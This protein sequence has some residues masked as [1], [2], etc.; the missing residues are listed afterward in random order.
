MRIQLCA[1]RLFPGQ[2]LEAVGQA[3]G[4]QE[5]VPCSHVETNVKRQA[6]EADV[7]V[8]CDIILANEV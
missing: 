4:G 6:L 8:L 7:L 2:N 5:T 1:A 3:S